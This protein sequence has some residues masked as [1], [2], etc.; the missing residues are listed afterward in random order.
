MKSITINGEVFKVVKPRKHFPIEYNPNAGRTLQDCYEHP[1][2]AK[3]NIY[4]HWRKWYMNADSVYDFGI[5]SYNTFSFSI[6]A[7]YWLDGKPKGFLH[8]TPAHNTIT[9]FEGVKI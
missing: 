5:T 6:G 2:I 1:S 4:E 9:L 7:I 8:I 3:Q